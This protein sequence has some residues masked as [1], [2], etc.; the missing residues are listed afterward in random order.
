MKQKIVSLQ[1]IRFE[2]GKAKILDN[3][4]VDVYAGDCIMLIGC[5]GSGKSSLLKIING[6]YRPISGS[7]E[8]L[9]NSVYELPL[10]K[11][12]KFISTM[13]QDP[14]LST[15]SQL[16]VYENYLMARAKKAP[17]MGF[18][19]ARD[20]AS[21][22]AAAEYLTAFN[23]HL[24]DRLHMPAGMLSGG[25]RQSLGLALC[26]MHSPELII[27]DEH[28]SALDPSSAKRVMEI[29][30][31]AVSKM[32]STAIICTHN[33]QDALCYGNRLIAMR[34]GR[35]ILDLKQEEK[36]L[37]SKEELLKIYSDFDG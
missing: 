35:I 1:D 28:T 33:L 26:L 36:T 30:S 8:L 14:D 20:K 17:R 5:N 2:I 7:I 31:E 11:R 18:F 22:I 23:P 21:Y 6:L 3:I 37:I 34:K 10:R 15:F 16:T 27:L 24:G 19:K 29:T 25:E 13:N 9:G 4:N 32:N 12:A